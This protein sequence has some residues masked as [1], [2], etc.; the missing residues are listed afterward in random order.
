MENSVNKDVF[1]GI[2]ICPIMDLRYV[3]IALTL[4]RQTSIGGRG[5]GFYLHLKGAKVLFLSGCEPK[6]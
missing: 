1:Y 2:V 4:D 3:N 5:L 6:D